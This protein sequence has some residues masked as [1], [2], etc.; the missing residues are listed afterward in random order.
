MENRNMK[1]LQTNVNV[2]TWCQGGGSQIDSFGSSNHRPKDVG[3]RMIVSPS[4]G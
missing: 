3:T 2:M 1:L 4:I